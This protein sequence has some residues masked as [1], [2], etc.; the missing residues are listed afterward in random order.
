MIFNSILLEK[1]REQSKAI[2]SEEI[3]EEFAYHNFIHTS[4]VVKNTYEIAS[5]TLINPSITEI[6][7]LLIAAWFHDVGYGVSKV[8]HEVYSALIAHTFLVKLNV[9]LSRINRIKTLIKATDILHKPQNIY[10]EIIKDA[11]LF[12]L[13][14]GN[15]IEQSNLLKLEWEQINNRYFSEVDWLVYSLNFLE[16]H[17]FYTNF[18]RKN[19]LTGKL[20]NI[21]LVKQKL[22]QFKKA[23]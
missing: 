8:N 9:K 19:C 15:F 10:E 3:S 20:E 14:Q 17:I 1:V 23:S 18:C 13:S 21:N 5:E 22:R 4:E 12:Y 16:N 2:H 6:E 11:D 7:N